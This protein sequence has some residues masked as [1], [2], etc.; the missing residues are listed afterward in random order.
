MSQEREFTMPTFA[1]QRTSLAT[2][3]QLRE[4]VR[5]RVVPSAPAV[6]TSCG[7]LMFC[8]PGAGERDG[9]L[10]LDALVSQRIRVRKGDILVHCG[11]AFRGLYAIR[12][13]SC[14]SVVTTAG[15]QEQLAG[16]H[17]SGDVIGAAAI[18]G[19]RH[20]ATVTALEDSEFCVIPLERM[21]AKARSDVGLQHRFHALMSREIGR[22]RKV[23][24]MLGAMRAEQRLAAFL[25]DL[26]ERYAAR[27]YSSSEFMLRMTREEIGCHLG[28]KLETV[29]RLFS[30]FHREGLIRVQG[31]D[32]RLIDRT[33][34]RQL[35]DAALH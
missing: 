22:E 21:E 34:L 26:A 5:L 11:D 18:F 6:C 10:Q 8:M 20:D 14:K 28:L 19:S 32:V 16:Y 29:S 35:V 4:T 12:S 31:R 3:A 24:L 1:L 9:G 17:I 15:G 25:L 7:S 2:P 13:G 33:A 23:M 27:G 30:R